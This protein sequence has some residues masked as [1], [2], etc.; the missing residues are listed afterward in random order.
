[1][2]SRTRG[3]SR[4]YQIVQI[5]NE[6]FGVFPDASE[7]PL[8]KEIVGFFLFIEFGG[9]FLSDWEKVFHIVFCGECGEKRWTNLELMRFSVFGLG[10]GYFS[11]NANVENVENSKNY[12]IPLFFS[13]LRFHSQNC[14]FDKA[15][16]DGIFFAENRS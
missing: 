5:T 2:L 6:V 3:K 12:T 15:M 11:T 8:A 10:K 1:M 4:I 14:R 7:K 16:R 13:N 9:I